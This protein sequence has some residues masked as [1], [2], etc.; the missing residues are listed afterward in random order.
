MLLMHR[1]VCDIFKRFNII[2]ITKLHLLP[3]K[4]KAL[5]A[6]LLSSMVLQIL[7]KCWA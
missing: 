3:V 5:E 2:I 1:N 6:C 7:Y 4:A